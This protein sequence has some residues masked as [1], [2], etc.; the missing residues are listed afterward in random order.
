MKATLKGFSKFTEK[1]LHWCPFLSKVVNLGLD[2]DQSK[3]AS[4]NFAKL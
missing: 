3:Y 2:L 1:Y 4:M